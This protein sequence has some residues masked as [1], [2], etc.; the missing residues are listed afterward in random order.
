M[1]L[2]GAIP[3]TFSLALVAGYPSSQRAFDSEDWDSGMWRHTMVDDLV[4]VHLRPG[5]PLA[6]VEELLGPL[7][8]EYGEPLVRTVSLEYTWWLS[9]RYY[10]LVLHFDGAD[11][12]VEAHEEVRRS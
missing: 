1:G 3:V 5:M 11:R 12:L 6:E 10:V 4:Q 2:L 9:D 7:H 8:P